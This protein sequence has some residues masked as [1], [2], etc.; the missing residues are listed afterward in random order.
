MT[1]IYLDYK[2]KSARA[3][4][5]ISANW[6]KDRDNYIHQLQ[7][8]AAG[9][10]DHVM[11]IT[12]WMPD[13]GLFLLKEPGEPVADAKLQ[14]HEQMHKHLDEVVEIFG[15]EDV[16]ESSVLIRLTLNNTHNG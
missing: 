16:Y 10:A 7:A 13:D 3:F 11:V 4:K 6:R 9:F 8:G 2:A 1:T 12:S 5:R 14:L 15:D